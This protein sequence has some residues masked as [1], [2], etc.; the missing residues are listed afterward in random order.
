MKKDTTYHDFV[1]YDLMAII[2]NISSRPMMSGWCIY[3]ENVPFAAIIGNQ[4]YLKAKGKMA[5]DLSMLDWKKFTYE[6]SNGKVTSMNYWRVP[7]VLIDDQSQF[8][9]IIEKVIGVLK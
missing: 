9:E 5:E 3:S 8:N 2:P 1:L 6:R 7:D 4:L